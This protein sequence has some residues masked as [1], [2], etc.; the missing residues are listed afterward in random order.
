MDLNEP[1]KS[2]RPDHTAAWFGFGIIT[3]IAACLTA[4]VITLLVRTVGC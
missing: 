4:I 3:V 2:D 1:V